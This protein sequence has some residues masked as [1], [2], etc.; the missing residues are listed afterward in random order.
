MK[1][2]NLIILI[3]LGI[4]F[5]SCKNDLEINAPYEDTAVVYGFLDQNQPVQYIRIQK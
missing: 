1:L 4:T 5:N 2:Q 3:L